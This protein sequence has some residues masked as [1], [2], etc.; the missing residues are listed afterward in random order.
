[1]GQ[2]PGELLYPYGLERLDAAT[3]LVSEF[4]GCRLQAFDLAGG[5]STGCW[6]KGGREPGML[7]GPWTAQVRGGT[8][9]VL[10]STNN[11]LYLMPS[12]RWTELAKREAGG[13]PLR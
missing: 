1:M 3:V 6:G 4:G 5:A 13:V 8:M 12:D 9:A 2:E 7:N 11:R 10:D